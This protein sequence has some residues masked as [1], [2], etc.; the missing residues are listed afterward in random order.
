MR[1][2]LVPSKELG[3]YWV[4]HVL[5]HKGAKHLQLAGRDL[6]F[7]QKHLLDVILF[8]AALA[9]VLVL[10]PVLFIRWLFRKCFSTKT[11]LKFQ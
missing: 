7:Y 3:A 1:D 2:E 9:L 8:L 4:E 5:S 6:P 11:K 10:I